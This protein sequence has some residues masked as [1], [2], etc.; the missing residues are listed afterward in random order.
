MHKIINII[1]IVCLLGVVTAPSLLA[2]VGAVT[3]SPDV[4]MAMLKFQQRLL[5]A[6]QLSIK[7][8]QLDMAK[9]K[10]EHERAPVNEIEAI[11]KR[12]KLRVAM[13]SKDTPPFYFMDQNN[14]LTGVDVVLIT[15]FADLLGIPVEFDRSAKSLDEVVDKVEHHQAD[16]AISKLSATFKR[17]TK[18]LFSDPYINLKQSLL[19][20]RIELAKQL[21]GRHQEEVIQHLTGKIGVVAK[22]SYVGFAKHFDQMEVV[23]Y[24]SWD[25]IIDDASTGK[26]MA[27]F[28]DDA[29]IKKILKDNPD[30]ALN[31]LS[32]VLTD[33]DD[34]KAIAVSFEDR[35][36]KDLLN[37]YLKSL[38]L[39]LTTDKITNDYYNVISTIE[40]KINQRL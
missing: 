25:E 28:R 14:V 39:N 21:Q 29:E 12:G 37:V 20:N 16:I 19:I 8:L 15:G 13:Y 32:V 22:S 24:K 30:K 6:Q 9:M 18:V 35:K 34:P 11:V 17:S 33:A 31:L 27:A 26:I 1:L 23:E 40:S 5:K 36:V 10:E 38:D 4:K 2:N 3:N 7:Y